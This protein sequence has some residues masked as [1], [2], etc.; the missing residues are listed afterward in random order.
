[1]TTKHVHPLG[2][3]ILILAYRSALALPCHLKFELLSKATFKPLDIK[4]HTITI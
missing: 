2:N 1:M 3:N 4:Y